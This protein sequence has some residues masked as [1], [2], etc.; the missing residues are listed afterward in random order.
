MS[1]TRE[2]NGFRDL[3]FL[4]RDRVIRIGE[5]LCVDALSGLI[6]LVILLSM[7]YFV[8]FAIKG[9]ERTGSN[10]V[11]AAEGKPRTTEQSVI[12]NQTVPETGQDGAAN[13]TMVVRIAYLMGRQTFDA[14]P[15]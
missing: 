12:P 3:G 14:H 8:D 6:A 9:I 11:A 7:A 1:D 15:I 5:L 4:L 2:V 10:A 13:A